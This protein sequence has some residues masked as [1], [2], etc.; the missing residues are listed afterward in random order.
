[1]FD[2]Y[3]K[4]DEFSGY[5]RLPGFDPFHFLLRRADARLFASRALMERIGMGAA[6]DFFA[7]NGVD[8]S[9]FRPRDTHASRSRFGIPVDGVYVGYFGS[10]TPD[11]GVEDLVAAVAMM[12][13]NGANVDLVLAGQRYGQANWKEHWIR[14]LG[15]LAYDQVPIAMA[16]CDI[17]ALP[18]RHSDYLDMA[19]SCKIV[20][21]I[22]MQLPLAVTDTPNFSMNFQEQAASLG[23]YMARPGAPHELARVIALQLENKRLV[24]MPKGFMWDSI[25]RR[26]AGQLKLQASTGDQCRPTIA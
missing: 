10:M 6:H 26:L 16:C 15:N 17:L 20:E 4:Y 23:S 5:L 2:V 3:D 25:A 19:S 24:S 12:R 11:R 9:R 14:F 1:V 22:A 18:Y 7:P 21:Y 13:Q 8:L